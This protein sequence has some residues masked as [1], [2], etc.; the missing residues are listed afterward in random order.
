MADIISPAGHPISSVGLGSRVVLRR[1]P[2]SPVMTCIAPVL[3]QNSER[4]IG[5]VCAWFNTTFSEGISMD[6]GMQTAVGGPVFEKVYI[7]AKTFNT[8]QLPIELI[9]LAEET[10]Q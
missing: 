7:G 6:T 8:I 5:W 3:P 9:E 10:V 1:D 4:I 2:H